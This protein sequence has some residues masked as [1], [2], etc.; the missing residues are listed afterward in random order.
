M[1]LIWQ[2]FL[3]ELE[4]I[5][6]E[7]EDADE[8]MLME[9]GFLEL[10]I[11]HRL[12][13]EYFATIIENGEYISWS[14]FKTITEEVFPNILPLLPP[15]S[16]VEI[17]MMADLSWINYDYLGV[18][19][20]HLLLFDGITAVDRASAPVFFDRLIGVPNFSNEQSHWD[21]DFSDKN[22]R[23]LGLFRLWNAMKYYFP[24]LD[25]LDV[26]WNGLLTEF[27]TRMLE[28]SDR[29]SYELTLAALAHHLH[30]GHVGFSGSFFADKFG[31]YA[32]P[33]QLIVAEGQFVVYEV[34]D[35]GS[36]LRFGDIILGLNGRD[37]DE[38]AEEMLQYLSYPNEEKA[39]PFLAWRGGV[40][41]A[42]M[43]HPLR[44][45]SYNMEVKVLRGHDEMM[46]NVI[47]TSNWVEFAPSAAQSHMILENNIGLINPS[48]SFDVHNVMTELAY[49]DGIIIDLRQ[50]PQHEFFLS[51]RQYLME[52]PLPFAKLSFPS[53]NNPGARWNET[54]NQYLPPNPRSFIY[55]RPVVL[56]MDERTQSHLEWVIMSFRVASNVTVIG[57]FSNGANGNVAV[58]PLPGGITMRF[59]SLGVYTLEGGQTHRI[60]LEPDLRVDRTV[61]GIRQGRDELMEVSI[62][63]ILGH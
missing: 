15:L 10:I 33:V 24:H 4:G 61:E 37:I 5:L 28:G 60:G 48:I 25:V 42:G 52:E 62:E 14:H 17:R 58:I 49:T 18:L 3:T 7:F 11:E 23:L 31:R 16:V 6:M 63:F 21:M 1:I 9:I 38:I 57:S 13:Q 19:A 45:H 12:L 8:E 44:S 27:I 36:S 20:E 29:L 54:I 30:D 50:R 47:G 32:A 46:L 51:M 43:Q 56:L 34:A 26:E 55:D 53:Q 35:S 59:T 22:Y 41:F 39:L 2:P 40:I